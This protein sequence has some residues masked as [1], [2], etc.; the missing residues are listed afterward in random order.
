[1]KL[2]QVIG[3]HLGAT[4]R[5][6]VVHGCPAKSLRINYFFSA[7]ASVAWF[8]GVSILTEAI[9]PVFASTWTSVMFF[10]PGFAMSN[11]Q[12]KRPCSLSSSALLIIPSGT[13]V[14]AAFSA[15]LF[16][17]FVSFISCASLGCAWPVVTAATSA[18]P[19]V[20]ILLFFVFIN[21]STHVASE[22]FNSWFIR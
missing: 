20:K 16:V 9:L 5:P 1:M 8:F 17:T 18:K 22:K 19:T 14:S 11:D 12:I 3:D 7:A 2:R 6:G 15:R 13:F 10:V 4:L 21:A